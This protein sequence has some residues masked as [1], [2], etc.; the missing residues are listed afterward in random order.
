MIIFELEKD[1][2]STHEAIYIGKKKDATDRMKGNIYSTKLNLGGGDKK[3]FFIR[4]VKH[5]TSTTEEAANF[6][7]N[8]VEPCLHMQQKS[9]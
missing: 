6:I 9:I 3:H 8:F 1:S 5:G 2:E 7:E 4:Y